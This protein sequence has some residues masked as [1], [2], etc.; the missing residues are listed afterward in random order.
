ML[1][2]NMFAAALV[3]ALVAPTTAAAL[4]RHTVREGET[5]TAIAVSHNTTVAE[6]ARLNGLDPKRL[7]RAETVV[8]IP[9]ADAAPGRVYAV[10]PGDTL[11]AIARQYRTTV[12]ALAAANDL[13]SEDVLLVGTRL[14]VLVRA[15]PAAKGQPGPEGLYRVRPGDTLSAIAGRYGLGMASLARANG[16]DP[17]RPLLAGATLHVPALPRASAASEVSY[18]VRPGDTLI[19]IAARFGMTLEELA[20]VNVL[21]STRVLLVGTTLRVRAALPGPPSVHPE[22]LAAIDRWAATYGLDRSLVRA[23][24]WMESGFRQDLVSGAGAVGVMQV[25]PATWTF[26]ETVLLGSLVAQ[27]TDGNVRV[28]VRYLRH[29]LVV[30][31]GDERL[32]LAA[33][34][35]GPAFVQRRGVLHESE[36]YVADILALRKRM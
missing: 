29:L 20:R 5:L 28:G 21:D 18:T 17:R 31:A 13:D 9:E 14:R 15:R 22:A 32:A 35:Q 19:A 7:L 4:A 25:L 23:L 10:A 1:L 33:Y 2:K 8:R 3:V 34:Y 30:F 6:L 26:V 11:T 24:A 16:L 27:T 12:H 36:E